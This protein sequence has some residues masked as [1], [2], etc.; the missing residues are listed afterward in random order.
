VVN[1]TRVLAL[2][3]ALVVAAP[4]MFGSCSS[5]A[6]WHDVAVTQ[7]GFTNQRSTVWAQ[8]VEYHSGSCFDLRLDVDRDHVP[9]QVGVQARRTSDMCTAEAGIGTPPSPAS[10]VVVSHASK[11]DGVGH[12]IL[13]VDLDSPAPA[14]V[15]LAI[16]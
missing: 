10:G 8:T 6:D 2:A 13:T 3:A 16:E 4:T 1:R 9:W 15:T 5:D 14:D 7:T 12:N 11:K